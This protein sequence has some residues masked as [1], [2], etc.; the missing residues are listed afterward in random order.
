MTENL[1]NE[2]ISDWEH[3]TMGSILLN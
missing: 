2:N 3:H 1:I